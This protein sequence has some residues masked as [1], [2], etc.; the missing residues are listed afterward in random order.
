MSKI[1]VCV[2]GTGTISDHHF[3]AY[4]NNPDV[5]IYGVYDYVYERAQ[6][7]LNNMMQ[8]RYLKI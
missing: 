6:K 3:K 5:T 2:I 4:A 7:K 8:K 1:N